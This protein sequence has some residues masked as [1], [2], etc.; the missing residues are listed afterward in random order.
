MFKMV[1]FACFFSLFMSSAA[2]A[3]FGMVIPSRST[4]I[5][6]KEAEVSLQLSFSHPM[7]MQG[8][9]LARPESFSVYFEGRAEDLLSGLKAAQ[10][11]GKEAWT[12]RYTPKRPGVYQF[13]MKPVPYWEPAE[14]CFI[15]HYTKTYLAAFGEEEGWGDPLGLE[16]EIVPLTRPFGNYAGNIFQGRVLLQGKPVPWAEVEVEYYNQ[17]NAYQAPDAYFVTQVVKADSNGVFSY[18]VP[19]AGWWGFAALNTIADKMEYEETP[20]DLEL[21]A[22]LWLEFVK[23]VNGK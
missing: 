3:H 22:V 15:Q 17:D 13:V 20:K 4:A 16:T 1:L 14:D 5:S 6:Q 2:L 10:V 23:P 12:A 7:E 18:V 8:M 19:F 9:P 21:G 11:M